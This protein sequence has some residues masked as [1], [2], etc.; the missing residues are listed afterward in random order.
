MNATLDKN[1]RD[2]LRIAMFSTALGVGV[3]SPLSSP[4]VH[5][6]GHT[7]CFF[8]SKKA[9]HYLLAYLNTILAYV[10]WTK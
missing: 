1:L 3:V 5:Y 2:L 9:C 6:L 8:C 7:H 10:V 4:S